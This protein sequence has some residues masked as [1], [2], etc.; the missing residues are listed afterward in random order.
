[1]TRLTPVTSYFVQFSGTPPDLLD[2]AI[3]RRIGRVPP[4]FLCGIRNAG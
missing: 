4:M 1:M 2:I 3:H